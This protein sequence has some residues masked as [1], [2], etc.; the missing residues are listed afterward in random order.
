MPKEQ[1]ELFIS[2]FDLNRLK[3]YAN[4]QADYHLVID[5]VPTLAKLYF[6]GTLGIQNFNYTWEAILVGVGLQHKTIEQVTTEIGEGDK[7]NVSNS[8]ALFHKAM[9]RFYKISKQIFEVNIHYIIEYRI[10]KNSR[11]TKTK[12]N[13]IQK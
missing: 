11:T 7:Y 2:L 9:I 8:L 6:S 4:N 12:C 13:R 5:L 1:F 10:T 3:S